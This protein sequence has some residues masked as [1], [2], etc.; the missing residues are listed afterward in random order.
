MSSPQL[1]PCEVHRVN[2][3]LTG[4]FLFNFVEQLFKFFLIAAQKKKLCTVF[5][6]ADGISAA[7]TIAGSGNQYFFAGQML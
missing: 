4:A 3:Y 7:D 1:L 6:K 5:R 2:C